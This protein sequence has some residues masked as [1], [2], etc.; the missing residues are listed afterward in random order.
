MSKKLSD[1]EKLRDEFRKE[2]NK[3]VT[4]S[5]VFTRSYTAWLQSKVLKYQSK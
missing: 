3:E 5:Y 2:T 1:I 4:E